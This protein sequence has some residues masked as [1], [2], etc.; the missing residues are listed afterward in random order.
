M[1]G[2][3]IRT[4]GVVGCLLR[5]IASLR[6]I[7]SRLRGIALRRIGALRRVATLLRGRIAAL[8]GRV[9]TLVMALLL[10]CECTGI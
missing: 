2:S 3:E 9:A 10:R 5:R 4:V 8:L 7:S 6:R 1:T